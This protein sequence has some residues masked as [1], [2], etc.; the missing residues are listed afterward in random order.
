MGGVVVVV[1]S[2]ACSIEAA[3]CGGGRGSISALG[4]PRKAV[5]IT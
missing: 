2:V 5:A 4:W 3:R 1:V